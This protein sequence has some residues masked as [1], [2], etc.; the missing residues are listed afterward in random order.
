[1]SKQIVTFA[2]TKQIDMAKNN[3]KVMFLEEA[4]SFIESLPNQQVTNCLK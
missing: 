4:L 1:M 2:L 3:P